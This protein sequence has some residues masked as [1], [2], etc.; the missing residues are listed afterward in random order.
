ME[1]KQSFNLGYVVIA[2]AFLL[3]FQAWLTA[4]RTAVIDD[5]VFL[6]YLKGG[7]IASVTVTETQVYGA[8]REPMDGKTDV[9]AIRVDPGFADGL[10][11]Y[12]VDVVDAHDR[13]W[14]TTLPF[15]ILPV[16]LVFGLWSLFVRRFAERQGLGGLGHVGKS[17]AKVYVE[18]KTGVT[19]KDVAGIDK[20]RAEREEIVSVPNDRAHDGR[21][22]A[23]VPKAILLAAANRPEILDPALLRSGRFDRQIVVDRPERT[24]RI[25]AADFPALPHVTSGSGYHPAP[26]AAHA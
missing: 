23:P 6:G 16:L 22:G 11:Q 13:T 8:V 19:F 18:R 14:L 20:A 15:W 12:A 26:E 9:A 3:M 5:R 7:N 25:G 21:L 24:G 4:A 1:R 17:K 2:V 10:A